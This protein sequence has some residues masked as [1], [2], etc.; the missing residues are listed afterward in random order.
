MKSKI[1]IIIASVFLLMLLTASGAYAHTITV[2][3]NTGKETES[4]DIT[5]TTT[6]P[7]DIAAAALTATFDTNTF[8]L[9][10][11]KSEFFDTFSNQWAAVSPAPDPMPPSSVLV[12]D[13]T[14]S[15]PVLYQEDVSIDPDGGVMIAG[16]QCQTG[17]AITTLFTLTFKINEGAE[18]GDYPLGIQKTKISNTAARQLRNQELNLYYRQ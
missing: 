10:E 6:D 9:E 5:I 1:S 3:E 14:Y 16:A 17:D 18:P 13:V 7:N 12:D 4:V 8:T 2:G 11:V 15:Q